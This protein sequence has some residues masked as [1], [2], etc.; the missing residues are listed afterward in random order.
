MEKNATDLQIT[1]AH[2][3]STLRR[4]TSPLTDDDVL[5]QLPELRKSLHRLLQSLPPDNEQDASGV[6][7][8]KMPTINVQATASD[9]DAGMLATLEEPA[10]DYTLGSISKWIQEKCITPAE[11]MEIFHVRQR[12]LLD[13][14]SIEIKHVDYDSDEWDEASDS[15]SDSD[16]DSDGSNDTVTSLRIGSNTPCSGLLSEEDQGS[17]STTFD[18]FNEKWPSF[19]ESGIASL[20][21]YIEFLKEKAFKDWKQDHGGRGR[22]DYLDYIAKRNLTDGEALAVV[23]HPVVEELDCEDNLVA[24]YMAEP[25][26]ETARIPRRRQAGLKAGLR[27]HF[28]LT[29]GKALDESLRR[30]RPSLRKVEKARKRR[31]EKTRRK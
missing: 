13:L 27:K 28:G 19:D 12:V 23:T 5:E 15:D 26:W 17:S 8:V 29:D 14:D 24:D 2:F 6:A 1:L 20:D 4:S 16:A 22:K 18:D 11:D 31:I 10:T 30:M 9:Q 3:C 25:E 7:G 21:K